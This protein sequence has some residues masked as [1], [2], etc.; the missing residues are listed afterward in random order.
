VQWICLD[1]SSKQF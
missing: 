1:C